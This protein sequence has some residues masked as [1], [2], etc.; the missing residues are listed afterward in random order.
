[1]TSHRGIECLTL[2]FL[3]LVRSASALE[4]SSSFSDYVQTTWTHRDGLRSTFV[5]SIVQ[6]ASGYIWLGTTDGLFRF[7]GVRFVQ[8]RA[9]TGDLRRLGVINALC[10]ARDGSLWVG[11]E[12]GIVGHVRGESLWSSNV[13]APVQAILEGRDGALWAATSD[14]LL[15]YPSNVEATAAIESPLATRFLSGPLQDRSGSIWLSTE[16]GVEQVGSLPDQ[17]RATKVL[18]GKFWL[19]QDASGG[20]WTTSGDGLTEPVNASDSPRRVAGRL[21]VR[22]TLH[23]SRGSTWIGTLGAGLFRVASR[24][25][26]PPGIVEF[27]GLGRDSI[28]SVFED[29]EQNLWVGT[30]NGLH[31][32]RDG[33]IRTLAT[34]ES[35]AG[36]NID[37]LA[38]GTDG[39]VWAATSDGIARIDGGHRE[40]YMSGT[41]VTAVSID[42]RNRL[43]AGTSLGV[44]RFVNGRREPVP[45]PAG[46]QLTSLTAIAADNQDDVWL[47]D[48]TRGLYRWSN[49]RTDDFSS[50]PLLRGKTILAS[51]ADAEGRVWF[52]LYEGGIV[53]F[54]NG[55]F[56]TALERDGLPAAPVTSILDDEEGMTWIGTEGGL[57]RFD[58]SRL[59]TWTT[60]DGLPGNR[61]LWILNDRDGQLWLGFSFGIAR[62][63]RSELDAAG[64]DRSHHI[65]YELLDSGDGLKG[66]P[67]R[68]SQSSAVEA[69]DGTL[70]FRTSDGVSVVDPRRL[71]KNPVAPPVQIEGM[72]ADG[73]RVESDTRIRLQPRTRDIQ[74]DYTALSLVEPRRVRFRYKLEGYDSAWQDAG[75]RRQAFYTNLPPRGYRFRVLACNNDGLWNEAGASQDFVLLPAFYQTSRF[76]LLGLLALAT[77]SWGAYRL[78]VRQLTSRLRM[79]FEERLAERTRIAQELHDNLLQSVLGISLQ[80]E[81]TDEL[82]PAGAPARPPL[83]QAL[84]LSKG[85]MAEGRRA[86]NELR[87]Q[88]LDADALVRAFSQVAKELPAAEIPEV[89]ILAEGDER[90]LNGVAGN[91]VLQIGRQAIANALQH[92][93]ARRIHVLLSYSRQN[94]CVAVK[95]NGQG[96]DENTLHDGKPDH[97]GLGGMRERAERIGATLTIVSRVGEGTEVSLNVPGH[98]IYEA[99]E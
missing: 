21:N 10:A 53:I 29:R 34:P 12:S 59:V 94:L 33:K 77:A 50:E 47:S 39:S 56:R 73:V 17:N 46:M 6:T 75:T 93:R 4:P 69:S 37:A 90:P 36:D 14:R 80:I 57:S 96:I 42:H 74:F 91:D 38:A 31:C 58:G 28:W 43:W 16:D 24:A 15:R 70:W 76:G 63:K 67:D 5:R 2:L 11:T 44:V 72:V 82:L 20:I 83:E 1:M 62:V 81:V 66:N 89:Q 65:E 51:Q 32:F 84:R 41:R 35:L 88:V 61:V 54:E 18:S 3:S 52:G 27:A 9:R 55:R 8:W 79:R 92:A 40:L 48:A 30:Q 49:G 25:G 13:R 98:V 22:T 23:D 60:M 97:Y 64:R 78:R 45:W 71:V 86:L 99:D 95:D 68:R 7:D 19:S 26:A 85:A 87:T